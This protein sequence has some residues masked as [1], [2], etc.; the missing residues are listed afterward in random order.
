MRGDTYFWI[1]FCQLIFYQNFPNFIEAKIDINRVILT[2]CPVYWNFLKLTLGCVKDGHFS[3]N[4]RS[5]QLG[6]SGCL[7]SQDITNDIKTNIIRRIWICV[8]CNK[9]LAFTR[10]LT[11]SGLHDHHQLFKYELHTKVKFK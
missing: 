8:H 5:C 1:R 9:W 4:Q 11:T 2:L 10:G 7:E 6:L 3:S